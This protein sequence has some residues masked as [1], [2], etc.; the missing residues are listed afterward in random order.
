MN[1]FSNKFRQEALTIIYLLVIFAGIVLELVKVV[2]TISGF[3]PCPSLPS[4]PRCKRRQKTV[5]MTKNYKTGPLF[6]N[7]KKSLSDIAP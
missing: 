7:A 4:V 6:L 3:N 1:K 5:S 2:L